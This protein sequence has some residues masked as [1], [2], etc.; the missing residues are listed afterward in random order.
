MK[1]IKSLRMLDKETVFFDIY[2]GVGLFGLCLED[3]VSE[4][5]MIE[6]APDSVKLA[7]Y[8]VLY[9]GLQHKI[10]TFSANTEDELENQL[11][12]HAGK[13]RVGM[14]DPPRKGLSDSVLESLRP[15]SLNKTQEELET[16][17]DGLLYLSCSP[18]S[19]ARDL[20]V[21]VKNGWRIEKMIPFDFFPRTRH[22]ETLAI[23]KP[24]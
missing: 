21:L 7:N 23:L 24:C 12:I 6:G 11:R 5:V 17:L 20:K 9:H 14:I 2:A 1:T 3:Q 22:L 13:K 15:A 4:V 19:L 18:E 16:A 10:K 8:N